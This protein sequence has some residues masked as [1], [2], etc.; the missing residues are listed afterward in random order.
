MAKHKSNHIQV[1]Y[2]NSTTDADSIVRVKSGMA[3]E[4]GI[5]VNICGANSVLA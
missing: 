4:L 5:D 3:A 1:A 2:A